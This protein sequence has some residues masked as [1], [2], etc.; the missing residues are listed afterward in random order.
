M[1]YQFT[2]GFDTE[3]VYTF[4]TAHGQ[5]Q[6]GNRSKQNRL[7]IV[8]VQINGKL[9]VLVLHSEKNM[10]LLKQRPVFKEHIS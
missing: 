3:T 5:L 10:E 8:G 4:F 6:I 1:K 2:N 7:L 9:G